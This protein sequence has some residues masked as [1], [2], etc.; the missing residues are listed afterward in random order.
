MKKSGVNERAAALACIGIIK[1]H[2][3]LNSTEKRL[4][5]A[6]ENQIRL[7]FELEGAVRPEALCEDSCITSEIPKVW[8]W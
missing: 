3:P 8:F 4:L 1:S 6:I 2:L 5:S 7:A